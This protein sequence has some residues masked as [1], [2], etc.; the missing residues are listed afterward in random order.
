MNSLVSRIGS[1]R[2]IADIEQQLGESILDIIV[3]DYQNQSFQGQ[4][5]L[6]LGYEK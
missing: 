1:G 4:Y 6:T 5:Q 2:L 3:L